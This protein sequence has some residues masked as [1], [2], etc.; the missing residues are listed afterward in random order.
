M[1][2]GQSF[3]GHFSESSETRYTIGFAAIYLTQSVFYVPRAHFGP[4]LKF[5]SGNPH[6]FFGCNY[7]VFSE[8]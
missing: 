7:L 4:Q 2:H 3:F 1:F 6:F 8:L 5:F